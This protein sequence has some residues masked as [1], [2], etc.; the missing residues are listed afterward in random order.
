MF[1]IRAMLLAIAFAV[2]PQLA[3][4]A[5]EVPVPAWKGNQFTKDADDPAPRPDGPAFARAKFEASR[6]DV[7]AL[8]RRMI[9][10]ARIQWESRFKLYVAGSKDSTLDIAL[11]AAGQ[12]RDAELAVCRDKSGRIA[13]LERFWEQAM[14]SERVD[15]ARFERGRIVVQ[16]LAQARYDRLSAEIQLTRERMQGGGKVLLPLTGGDLP[17][18]KDD[19]LTD[20]WP[21][22]ARVKFEASQPKLPELLRARLDAARINFEARWK[23]YLAGS[24]ESTLH[25]LL[26]AQDHL[27]VAELDGL[28]G[29]RLP[30]LEARWQT[31]VR[32][33]EINRARFEAVR[34][35]IQDLAE[36]THARVQAEIVLVRA[37]RE[38]K[39]ERPRL[40]APRLLE[41]ADNV[42]KDYAER[43][44][45]LAQADLGRLL[46]E[47]L[48]AARTDH[49]ARFR[50]YMAGSRES[51]LDVLLSSSEKLTDIELMVSKDDAERLARLER[52]WERA[53]MV[54]QELRAR[55]EA[56]RVPIQDLAQGKLHR[57]A[58]ELRWAEA[59]ASKNKER[60]P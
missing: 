37:L 7:A 11:E 34:I 38:L 49:E 36:S 52:H 31:A 13:V 41:V 4:K 24:K 55:F 40:S 51:T 45:A 5:D 10:T 18:K 27:L 25:I 60:S 23:L 20:N 46:E 35:P 43:R 56:G 26:A 1:Y 6:A 48:A 44:A 32:V 29:S 30:L 33:E 57:L 15:Q 53:W 28:D 19:E 16:D 9:D 2:L 59:R 8:R 58:A 21:S 47:C 22:L 39:E 3:A 12:L 42:P 50:L 54:E 14:M 17:K